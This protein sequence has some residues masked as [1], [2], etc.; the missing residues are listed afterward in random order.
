MSFEGEYLNGK[1][2]NGK[3][4][5]NDKKIY[6]IKDGKGYIKLYDC[7]ERL[8]YEGQYSKGQKNGKGKE[9]L[10]N[11][12]EYEGE[13]ING[14]RNGKGK[15]YYPNGNL[16]FEGTYLNGERNGNGKLYN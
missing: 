7:F 14:E 16:N 13:Y 4:Y 9:Y 2:W 12:L 5:I 11:I 10:S 8:S 6:D 3:G 15:E 1:K